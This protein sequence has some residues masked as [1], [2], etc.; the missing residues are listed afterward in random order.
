M[1]RNLR[2]SIQKSQKTTR[3]PKFSQNEIYHSHNTH[4][5][6]FAKLKE[7]FENRRFFILVVFKFNIPYALFIFNVN[8]VDGKKAAKEETIGK[9]LLKRFLKLIHDRVSKVFAPVY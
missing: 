7:R 2:N 1:L 4:T 9:F 5:F 3:K 6:Y 8:V